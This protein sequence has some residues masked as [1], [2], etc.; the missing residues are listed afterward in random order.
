M[1][2]EDAIGAGSIPAIPACTREYSQVS[3]KQRVRKL[4]KA[5]PIELE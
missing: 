4:A 5:R 1:T 2:R 3:E